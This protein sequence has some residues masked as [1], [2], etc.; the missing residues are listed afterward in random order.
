MTRSRVFVEIGKRKT[1][2][3]AVGWPGWCRSGWDERTALQTLIDYGPRHAQVLHRA[4]ADFQSPAEPSEL[5]VAERHVGNATTDFGPPAIVLD[6]DREPIDQA[7]LERLQR[8]LL[9][10]WHAFDAALKQAAGRALRKGSRGGGRELDA[11]VDHILD[12]GLAY[13][14]RRAWRHTTEQEGGAVGE[15]KPTRQAIVKALDAAIHQG[16]PQRGPR[17]GIIGPPRHF[18]RRVAWHVLYH[19][20]EIED[21]IL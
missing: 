15:R 13:L 7:E 16:L 21:R 4:G 12:A 1:F 19:T 17:G 3:A 6:A 11:I 20:W 2:A 18:V 9:P 8:L 5:I 14:G 10:C